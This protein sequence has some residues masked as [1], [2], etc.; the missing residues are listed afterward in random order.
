MTDP[1]P[2][3]PDSSQEANSE[4]TRKPTMKSRWKTISSC[5]PKATVANG[6]DEYIASREDHGAA[7]DR[8]NRAT[9]ARSA[10]RAR[11]TI[12]AQE[13]WC[14]WWVRPPIQAK[15]YKLQKLRCNLCGIVF[16][17]SFARRSWRGEVRRDSGQYDC[18]AEVRKRDALPSPARIAR[19]SGAIPLPASTQWDI[20]HA[21]A[22]R[23][24]AGLRRVDS[25]SG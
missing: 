17:S 22:E 13:S 12:P 16:M 7:L 11:S 18:S 8:S 4:V 19:E 21:K 6:A 14:G 3:C 25:A 9:P 15:I 24:R 5:H 10:R 2:Q 20:V 1:A 23:D